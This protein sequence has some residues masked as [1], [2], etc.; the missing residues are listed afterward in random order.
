VAHTPEQ[1]AP[2]FVRIG[3]Y[4]INAEQIL[5]IYDDTD[6]TAGSKGDGVR[7]E[8]IRKGT[9]FIHGQ[10]L[11]GVTSLLNGAVF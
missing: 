6:Y 10:T 9:L 1:P 4:L 3:K 8:F 7:V 2:R 11:E 5:H